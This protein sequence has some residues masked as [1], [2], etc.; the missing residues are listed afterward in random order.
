MTPPA[1][2][3]I[4]K[5]PLRRAVLVFGAVVLLLTGIGAGLI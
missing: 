1:A 5:L 3:H 2:P 4:E